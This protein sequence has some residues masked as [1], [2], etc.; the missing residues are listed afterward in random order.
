G[1]ELGQGMD[2][3]GIRS[4]GGYSAQR[5]ILRMLDIFTRHDIQT[6]FFVP[7]Y[8]A[9]ANPEIVQQIIQQ[10][11]EVAAHGYLHERFDVPPDEEEAL[12]RKSHQ[13]LTEVTGSA[14]SGWRSPGGKKSD[15]T[16]KVHQD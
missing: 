10:G 6:T 5:G 14:P 1:N 15:R 8:D 11:H 9:E 16:A 12:L 3:V 7:G 13:I 2:P 4:A